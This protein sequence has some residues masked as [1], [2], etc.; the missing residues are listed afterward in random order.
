VRLITQ[1]SQ[2][3][4]LAPLPGETAFQ[5]SSG[6]PFPSFRDQ[7][8]DQLWFQSG[9]IIDIGLLRRIGCVV[10]GDLPVGAEEERGDLLGRV[11]V[12]AL[13]AV[14]VDAG[15]GEI[16]TVAVIDACTYDEISPQW[17]I[18]TMREPS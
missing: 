16:L 10:F 2:V 8:C 6:R 11:A 5:R 7:I 4:I 13:G 1:R 15:W 3:Q 14:A 9:P 12:L 17:W 18:A